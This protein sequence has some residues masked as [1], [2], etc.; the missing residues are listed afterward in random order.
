[1]ANIS[2]DGTFTQV[3]RFDVEPGKQERLIAAIVG[4]LERWVCRRPGFISSTFH[5]S[6]DGAHVLNYAQWKDEASFK[7]FSADPEGK[8]LSATIH[9]VD[10]LLKPHA[11]AY[12]VVRSINPAF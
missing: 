9:A 5:A 3:V 8:Q 11:I 10:P 2:E 12:R 7:G 1:M 4:E 6:L